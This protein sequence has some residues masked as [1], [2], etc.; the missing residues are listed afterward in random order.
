MARAV[1]DRLVEL[2][3]RVRIGDPMDDATHVGPLASR[4]QFEKVTALVE[5]FIDKVGAGR[6][7]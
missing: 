2:I 7:S 6:G 3:G 1:L 4:R 5:S